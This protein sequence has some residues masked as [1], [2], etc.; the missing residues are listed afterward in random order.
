MYY[1]QTSRFLHA[2]TSA[3]E[4]NLINR[5]CQLI[6]FAFNAHARGQRAAVDGAPRHCQFQ[7]R[8]HDYVYLRASSGTEKNHA[9]LSR[10]SLPPPKRP[11]AIKRNS[12]T[13]S[14]RGKK[15]YRQIW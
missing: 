7:V 6:N 4:F 15:I 9:I 8:G 13:K 12:Y 3:R 14:I 10:L 5:F 1:L 2:R 11:A